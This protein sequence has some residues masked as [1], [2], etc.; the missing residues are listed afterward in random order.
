MWD[1]CYGGVIDVVTSKE[2]V[3]NIKEER[4]EL[5]FTDTCE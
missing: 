3:N 4:V 5:A 1:A 2:I